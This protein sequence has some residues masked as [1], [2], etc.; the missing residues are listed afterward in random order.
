LPPI[1]LSDDDNKK[2][3][4]DEDG[5]EEEINSGEE[6]YKYNSILPLADGG[7]NTVNQFL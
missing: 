5:Y 4:K 3:E 7:E 1:S 2:E 6:G